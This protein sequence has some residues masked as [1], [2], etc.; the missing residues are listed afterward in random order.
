MSSGICPAVIGY[1]TPDTPPTCPCI[2]PPPVARPVPIDA[3]EA[4][5]TLGILIAIIGLIA[6]LRRRA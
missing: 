6:V 1:C 2:A 5:I 4:L 3:P